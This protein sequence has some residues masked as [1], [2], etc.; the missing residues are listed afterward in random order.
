MRSLIL[1][2]LIFISCE[3]LG[4]E[5]KDNIFYTLY[6]PKNIVYIGVDNPIQF[7]DTTHSKIDLIFE[8]KNGYIFKRLDNYYLISSGFP[9]DTIILTAFRLIDG[10]IEKDTI[11]VAQQKFLIGIIT[12]PILEFNNRMIEWN[13]TRLFTRKELKEGSLSSKIP[14]CEKWTDVLIFRI[15][16][17][18]LIFPDNTVLT[19]NN[20]FFTKEM[21]DKIEK[22]KIGSKI[23]ITN[24]KTIGP[25]NMEISAGGGYIK[26]KD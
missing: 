22:L 3:V 17:F 2:T 1:I 24:V 11:L 26:I 14:D 18:E 19:S 7:V 21:N 9:K 15:I 5:I 6:S 12:A 16:Y 10:Y 20:A 23:L 4:Q 25:G 8:I 13:K